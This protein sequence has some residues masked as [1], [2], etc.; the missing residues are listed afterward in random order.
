MK[1]RGRREA[2]ENALRDR[3]HTQCTG[4]ATGIKNVTSGVLCERAKGEGFAGYTVRR[5]GCSRNVGCEAQMSSA[6]SLPQTTVTSSAF[7]SHLTR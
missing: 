6:A 1:K 5:R 2:A 7:P 4:A 3:A